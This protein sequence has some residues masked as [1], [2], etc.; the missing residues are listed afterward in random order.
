MLELHNI[1]YHV[2]V[3]NRYI[4]YP[5]DMGCKRH[6]ERSRGTGVSPRPVMCHS[7][8]VRRRICLGYEV[9][10][11]EVITVAVTET[12][13]LWGNFV[14]W[15]CSFYRYTVIKYG[16]HSTFRTWDNITNYTY[17]RTYCFWQMCLKISD[18]FA[19]SV[20]S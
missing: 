5:S 19:Y 7:C 1:K 20:T 16:I 2:D 18:I 11:R 17:R 3:Q 12:S 10:Q 8:D 6:S 14:W 15:V 9:S 13:Y 4:K